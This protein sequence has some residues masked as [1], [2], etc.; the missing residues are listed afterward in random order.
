[1]V[2]GACGV[3]ARLGE[4]AD[5]RGAA[6]AG[7][8]EQHL[9]PRSRGARAAGE[10][11]ARAVGGGG[12]AGDRVGKAARLGEGAAAVP[13]ED[14][15]AEAGG[16]GAAREEEP[17]GGPRGAGLLPGRGEERRRA[18]GGVE[19]QDRV[20]GALGAAAAQEEE[21]ALLRRGGRVRERS[22]K[23]P[24]GGGFPGGGVEGEDARGGLAP[25]GA[26]L[27]PAEEEE[28][29]AHGRAAHAGP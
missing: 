21:V 29:V 8:E 13:A 19:A 12:R 1:A 22:R 18:R 6:P 11:D 10:P 23:P 27:H 25:R 4:V 9:V 17:R 28:A 26:A 15:I 20:H 24:E 2:P 3:P 16:R 14:G 5:H 7:G